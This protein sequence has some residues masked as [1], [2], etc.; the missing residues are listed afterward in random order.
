MMRQSLNNTQKRPCEPLV[1]PFITDLAE[2]TKKPR[3]PDATHSWHFPPLATLIETIEACFAHWH[4]P[5]IVLRRLC[6]IRWV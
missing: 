4:K 2:R 5:T 6:N 3:G 1:C